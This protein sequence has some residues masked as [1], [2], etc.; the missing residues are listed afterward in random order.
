M[1]LSRRLVRSEYTFIRVSARFRRTFSPLIT[2]RVRILNV[3][4]LFDFARSQTRLSR[5]LETVVGRTELVYPSKTYVENGF[6]E[7]PI[8][9]TSNPMCSYSVEQTGQK[10]HHFYTGYR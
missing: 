5:N 2:R 7:H 6:P 3:I 8:H 1:S 10:L 9:E 4:T